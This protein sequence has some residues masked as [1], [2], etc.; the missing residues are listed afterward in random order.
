MKQYY[1]CYP[2]GKFKALTLSY[3]DGRIEDRRL[4]AVLNQF[5][6]KATFHLNGGLMDRNDRT[7][8]R[9]SLDEARTLYQ[10][11]EIACHTYTHPTIARCPLD[12]VALEV[13]EDRRILEGITGIP[14]Q[15]MSYPNGSY[16]KKIKELLPLLGINYSRIVGSS[17]SFALPTDWYAW[18][19]T[20]HHQQQLLE[21][22]K[23]FVD[24]HKS[25]YLYLMSVWGHS[26]EFT[27]NNN[28]HLIE[29]FAEMV[30]VHHDIWFVTHIDFYRYMVASE[31]LV[32]SIEGNSVYNPTT[33]SIWISVDGNIIQVLPG[34]NRL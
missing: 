24:L 28:W 3:D 34:M 25:Q 22:G 32:F 17:H 2:E 20:C 16:T 6:L 11:H 27:D 29:D 12:K 31:Q 14:I 8:Q 23:D 9:I 33:L 26:Y 18:Q 10:G 1:V 7:G 30:G 13:I 5:G 19:A 21:H 4:I 15:G